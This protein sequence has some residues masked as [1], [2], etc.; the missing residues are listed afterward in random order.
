MSWTTREEREALRLRDEGL[1]Y[2]QIG[3]R[4]GK[5]ASR[6]W[7]VVHLNQN[8]ARERAAAEVEAQH[9]AAYDQGQKARQQGKA[10]AAPSIMDAATAAF[11]LAGWH[12]ADRDM[13]NSVIGEVA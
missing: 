5:A 11:F 13:G 2:E 4:L 8:S 12:D 3:K 1:S 6:V 10:K 9:Q 7:H